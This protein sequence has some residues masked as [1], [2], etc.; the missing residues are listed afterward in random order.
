MARRAGGERGDG[1]LRAPAD[2]ALKVRYPGLA[3]VLAVDGED[4]VAP[5]D[6]LADAENPGAFQC[7]P[8]FVVLLSVHSCTL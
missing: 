2:F 8:F 5:G 7:T 1:L 3:L 4:M 6:L